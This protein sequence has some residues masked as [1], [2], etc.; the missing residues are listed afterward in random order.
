MSRHIETITADVIV[1]GGG[2]AGLRASIEARKRG[3]DVILV[4]RSRVGYGNNSAISWAEFA[5]AAGLSDDRDSPE[6][7]FNDTLAAG[8]NI[9]E[10]N[11]VRVLTEGS[12]QQV[13]DLAEF[14]VKYRTQHDRT[15]IAHHPGHSYPRTVSV[16]GQ[17][18]IGFSVPMSEYARKT[19]VRFMEDVLITRL[20]K[21]GGAVLGAFG[22]GK[23]RDYV[24]NAASTVLGTGG[25]G[26]I[27]LRTS[28]AAE[29]T[30][31]GY[32]LAYQA[33]VPLRDMEFVQCFP[34]TSGS[35]GQ[36]IVDFE[37]IVPVGG[38]TVRNRLGEDILAKHG[39]ADP[40]RLTRDRLTR[41]I[42]SEIIAG[43]DIDGMALIDLHDASP[44][45]FEKLRFSLP[46]R[47]P[48]ERRAILV[49]PAVHFFMGGLVINE[50]AETSL[51]GL[52][53][54]GEVCGGL[55]GANRLAANAL[56]ECFV[57]G[58][59]AGSEA[60]RKAV[61]R[62][63]DIPDPAEIRAEAERLEQLAAR[64][65]D[66]GVK[67]LV[68][69][70]RKTMWLNGGPVRHEVGLNT[71]LRDIQAIRERLPF[72]T[73]GSHNELCRR[74]RLENML[75]VAEIICRSARLRTE[76][77]GGH[78]RTDFPEQKDEWLGS[79]TVLKGKGEPELAVVPCR[80]V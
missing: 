7:Y 22:L 28:N 21:K 48:P 5:A 37:K 47:Y 17:L 51:S 50:R 3:A 9:N 24:L 6:V 43:R 67:E 36:T 11:L 12:G 14:G 46:S 64:R 69:W 16:E 73:T 8:G 38:V 79:V 26:Q 45:D 53:A 4:S 15:W 1:L 25:A 61:G 55:H 71:A 66:S 23:D 56:A 13:R 54:A 49:A 39:V 20:L 75:I 60:A 30:G 68:E 29:A 65:G 35:R 72:V 63:A 78:Y 58:T 31:D 62:K 2:A 40:L 18:G 59:I 44:E 19:G 76:S 10:R 80:Q 57:F 77:R 41:A 74:I 33:G 42:M 27:F 52:Y 34:T 32:A 70:L